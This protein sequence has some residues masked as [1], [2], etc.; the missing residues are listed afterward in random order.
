[1]LFVVHDKCELPLDSISNDTND[2]NDSII[3]FEVTYVFAFIF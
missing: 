3:H 2:T 1:M